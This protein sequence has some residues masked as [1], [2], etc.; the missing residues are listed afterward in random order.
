MTL[1]TPPRFEEQGS[2]ET[3]QLVATIVIYYH[4]HIWI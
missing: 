1:Y 3:Y 2:D 4:K